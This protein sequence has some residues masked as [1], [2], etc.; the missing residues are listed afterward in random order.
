MRVETTAPAGSDGQID[1]TAQRLGLIAAAG[2]LVMALEIV[3]W[4]TARGLEE[5]IGRAAIAR[6]GSIDTSARRA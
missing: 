1:R 6:T 5:R 2:E 4:P 3:P